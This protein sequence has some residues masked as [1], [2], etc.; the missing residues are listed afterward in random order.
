[1]SRGTLPVHAQLLQTL[2]RRPFGEVEVEALAGTH[3]RREQLDLL[4]TPPLRDGGHN[5]V[6]GLRLN[7]DVALGTELCAEFGKQQPQEM[8]RPAAQRL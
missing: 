2:A 8:I 6:H 1:M 3:A 7:G 5:R 4:A